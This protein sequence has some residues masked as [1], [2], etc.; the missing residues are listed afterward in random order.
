MTGAY[1][2]R[3]C[4]PVLMFPGT[5][6]CRYLCSP[7][8]CSRYL[9]VPRYLC[10]PNLCSPVPLFPGTYVPRTYV[11]RYLCSPVPMFPDFWKIFLSL[12][13][14]MNIHVVIFA[15]ERT[16]SSANS[17]AQGVLVIA[18]S[19]KTSMIILLLWEANL[20][21]VPGVIPLSLQSTLSFH[22]F[23]SL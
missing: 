7:N 22:I 18:F 3:L 1:L 2:C 9:Y 23:S 6:V 16:K 21:H 11:P 4:S 17:I 19:A 8:L 12:Q 14:V 20:A 13:I 5:Y 15:H 10:S